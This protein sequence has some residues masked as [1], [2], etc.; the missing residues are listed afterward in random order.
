MAGQKGGGGGQENGSNTEMILLVT[1]ILVAL[2]AWVLWTFARAAIVLPAFVIDYALVFVIEHTKGIGDVGHQV[3]D[4][5][6]AFFTG[7]RQASADITWEQFA[8]VRDLVHS[9]LKWVFS[10][11]IAV[12]AAVVMFK[13]KGQ[14]YKRVFSLG[15]GKGKPQSLAHYQSERWKVATYSAYFDPDGRDK[16]ITQAATPMEFLRDNGIP[17][18]N[19]IFTEDVRE[20]KLKETFIAQLGK[21]WN[22]VERADLSVQVVLVLCALHYLRRKNA[23]AERETLSVAWAQGRDGSAA[24][25]DL[26]ER[27][28]GPEKDWITAG[29]QKAAPAVDKEGKPVPAKEVGDRDVRKV[30]K[31]ICGKHAY[32][33]PGV[34]AI[35]DKARARGGVLASADFGYIKQLDRT[36]WYTL[37]NCGRRRFFI[38]AAGA[39]A[40]FFAERVTDN[41]LV[42]ANVENAL[43]GV[44]DYLEEQGL[45]S[46]TLFFKEE[47]ILGLE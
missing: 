22:G 20:G 30:I 14:G 10:A 12:M 46:L 28:L 25:K 37:S 29:G 15:G 23:L 2:G 39:V 24:M 33:N 1:V 41:P 21:P 26:V 11:A 18:E 9:Q 45:E 43:N 40:H 38:E 44:E 19:G 31:K 3:K 6:A 27:Y 7:R 42:D 13:M 47:D 16:H 4:F 36:L 17:Y 34:F 35:L 8:M 32:S 5:I